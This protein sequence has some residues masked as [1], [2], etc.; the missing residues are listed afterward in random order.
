M[1]TTTRDRT[2]E[3]E[4]LRGYARECR[5]QSERKGSAAYTKEAWL[6][7]ADRFERRA[8]QLAALIAAA[9]AE[10]RRPR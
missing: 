6:G 1:E 10:S 2:K 8:E 9:E 3:V 5:R 4:K 7:Q